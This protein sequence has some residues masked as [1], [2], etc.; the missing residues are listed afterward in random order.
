MAV[1]AGRQATGFLGSLRKWAYNLSGFNR[2]GLHHDD[3]LDEN[4]DVTEALR[5]LPQHLV[6]ERNFR[7]TRAL[8]L[9][10][11]K[12]YLPKE[13]WTKWEEDNKYLQPYLQEVI[14]ERQEREE[15][16]KQ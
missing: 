13:Q 8:Q 7:I 3:C 12:T 4:A 16:N 11:T 15:W 1:N 14:K 6:D 9:S 2:Y 10:M 5:R